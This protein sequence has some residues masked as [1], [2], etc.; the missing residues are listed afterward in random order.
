LLTFCAGGRK[1]LL[2]N[3]PWTTGDYEFR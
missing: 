2:R 3:S 1:E